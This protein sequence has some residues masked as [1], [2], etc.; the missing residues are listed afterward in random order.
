MVLNGGEMHFVS[1]QHLS[2]VAIERIGALGL[3]IILFILLT[4][5]M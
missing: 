2:K 3:L 4:L 5:V 1:I